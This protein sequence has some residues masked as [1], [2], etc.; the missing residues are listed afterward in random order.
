MPTNAGETRNQGLEV[1]A[2]L[3]KRRV[4]RPRRSLS[5]E[6]RDKQRRA[7]GTPTS[8]PAYTRRVPGIA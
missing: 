2:R 3:E 7:A 6:S 1:S 5:F 4:A 8:I